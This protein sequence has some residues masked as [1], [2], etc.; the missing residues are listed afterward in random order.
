MDKC[1]C[2]YPQDSARTVKIVDG[3][4]ICPRCG[5]EIEFKQFSGYS[6]ETPKGDV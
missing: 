4:K 5:K 2:H 6:T 3:K 1:Q